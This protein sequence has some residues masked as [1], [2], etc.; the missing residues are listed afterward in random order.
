MPDHPH[1]SRPNTQLDTT[2]FKLASIFG[3]T[4]THLAS[5][6]PTNPS[7]SVATTTS[8][9]R[10]AAQNVHNHM[11]VWYHWMEKLVPITQ[12]VR[13]L[14]FKLCLPGLKKQVC[15]LFRYYLTFLIKKLSNNKFKY[16]STLLLTSLLW[17][18]Y[19]TPKLSCWNNATDLKKI[20]VS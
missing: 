1:P 20:S 5:V 12:M 19:C 3:R 14:T 10:K 16:C 13:N 6:A 4:L 18:E 2:S 7:L 11:T 8:F 15:H 9:H 17:N